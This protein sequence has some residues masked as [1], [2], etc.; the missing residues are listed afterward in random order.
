MTKLAFVMPKIK[1]CPAIL[2]PDKDIVQKDLLEIEKYCDLL[3]VDIMDNIFVPNKTP[4]AEQLKWFVTTM[5][6]Q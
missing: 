2:S 4:Q 3:Q 6:L 5:P 1:I